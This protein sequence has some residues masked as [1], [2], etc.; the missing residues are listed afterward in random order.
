VIGVSYQHKGLVCA[1]GHLS[2]NSSGLQVA[3]AVLRGIC[4]NR[5]VAQ[6]LAAAVLL[7]TFTVT[8]SPMVSHFT[9][10]CDLG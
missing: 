1:V 7:I 3:P 6:M 10:H 8:V 5:T 4:Q 9:Q 2:H